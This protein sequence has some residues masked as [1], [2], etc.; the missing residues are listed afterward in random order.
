MKKY[1]GTLSIIL[2]LMA[3]G[4]PLTV[5]TAHADDDEYANDLVQCR[6]LL[7]EGKF[8]EAVLF[9]DGKL[10]K[11]AGSDKEY[12]LRILK[13]EALM[14][15][16][17]YDDAVAEL[18]NVRKLMAEKSGPEREAEYQ[19]LSGALYSAKGELQ[20]AGN[21][22]SQALDTARKSNNSR[23]L[24]SVPNNAALYYLRKNEQT[25]ALTLIE[26]AISLSGKPADGDLL[27]KL[28]V[29]KSNAFLDQDQTESAL[30]NMEIAYDKYHELPRSY[31][32]AKG[33][34][35]VGDLLFQ[36]AETGLFKANAKILSKALS[37]YNEALELSIELSA[38]RF[39]TYA[40][41][42]AGRILEINGE[43]AEALKQ[44]RVAIFFA[45]QDEYRDPLYLWQWQAA[46]ILKAQGKQDEAI[47]LS[48]LAVLTLQSIKA[49]C[50]RRELDHFQHLVKPVYFELL[51]LLLAKAAP[52]GERKNSQELLMEAVTTIE[53]LKNDELTDY[54]RDSCRGGS[55]ADFRTTKR[56]LGNSAI[57]YYLVLKDRIECL[58]LAKS[59]L[60][61]FTIGA[62]VADVTKKIELFRESLEHPERRYLKRSRQLYDL[63]IAPLEKYL[64]DIDTLVFVADGAIRLVPMAALHDG[65]GFLLEKYAI[66]L[67]QGLTVNER[68]EDASYKES[69]IFLGGIAKSVNGLDKIPFVA[70]EM[71]KIHLMYPGVVL[72]DESFTI[73]AIT[74]EL[75]NK[76]YSI[77]HIASH[78][79]FSGDAAKSYIVAWDGK[80][81]IDKLS[82]FIR[83][84]RSRKGPIDLLTLSACSTA[85]GDERASLGLA[86]MALKAGA[87]S[88]IASL[89]DVNDWATAQFFIGYYQ[90]LKNEPA[91]TKAKA[92]RK[93]QLSMLHSIMPDEPAAATRGL[94]PRTSK[95][96]DVDAA[97]SEPESTEL[98]AS[99]THPYYWA[100]FVLTGDWP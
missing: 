60:K 63:L 96:G 78:G 19:N 45:Q 58:L 88:V 50:S 7:N 15:S 76:N 1:L 71:S 86:G 98:S 29:T 82:G 32:R 54:L 48:R 44:T 8:R 27:A 85:A 87:K 62:S 94:N 93:T 13:T 65:K 12:A 75:H 10:G 26:E 39:A 4:L 2:A 57:I 92:L 66:V 55:R 34:L 31:D 22:F 3:I 84:G 72:K 51:D 73:P 90:L 97:S 89:W 20:E 56:H 91:L 83:A 37:A 30:R 59:E 46:R 36:I 11:I 40:A 79:Q 74:E 70:E 25:V 9:V 33:L 64:T 18:S 49:D 53:L 99:Y 21:C 80:L 42:G 38:G 95:R 17:R 6:R 69:S 35:A 16:E 47:N 61:R 81:D 77:L 100:P 24:A 52:P 43:Y 23:L 67:T 14:E 5:V 41:G 28:Y 68:V